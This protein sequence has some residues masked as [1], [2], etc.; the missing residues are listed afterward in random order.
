MNDHVNINVGGPKGM[1]QMWKLRDGILIHIRSLEALGVTGKQCEV[2]L[3]P[4]ILFRLPSELRLEW[5]R[6]GDGHE[7]DLD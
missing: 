3:T 7:S 6:D 2:F 1:A 4:V 5:A